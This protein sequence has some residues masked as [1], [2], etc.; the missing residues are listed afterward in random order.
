[1]IRKSLFCFILIFGFIHP[2]FSQS[3][4]ERV[5]RL[6]KQMTLEEK[7]GQLL[8]YSADFSSNITDGGAAKPME[9]YASK[10]VGCVLNAV[11]DDLVNIQKELGE[12]SRLG[13]PVLTM[14]DAINGHSFYPGTTI[15]PSQLALSQSWDKQLLYDVGAVTAKE[16]AATGIH[17]NY[18]PGLDVA[19]DLRWG[20]VGETIGEDPYLVGVLGASRIRGMQGD[21]L[22]QEDKVAACAKHLVGYGE[23][24]GGR[25]ATETLL[26]ERSLR[27]Y[28]LPPFKMAVQEADVAT[29]M[30]GYHSVLGV[31]A[32]ANPWLLN[33]LLRD[34][35]GFEGFVVSDWENYD[36]LMDTHLT[37]GDP[38]QAAI[39]IISA[40]NDVPMSAYQLPDALKT[41]VEKGELKESVIDTACARVLA[42]KFKLGL[43]DQESKLYPHPDQ[44]EILANEEHRKLALDAAYQSIVLLENKDKLLPL[45]EDVTSIAVIGPN[46]DDI[47]A[48]LGDWSLGFRGQ[49]PWQQEVEARTKGHSTILKG[50]RKRAG[51]R[52]QVNYA[53]A[54]DVLGEERSDIPTA[55]EVAKASDVIVAVVGDNRML[56]GEQQD[57]AVLE[58]TGDQSGLIEQLA[59]T[60]KPLITVILASKPLMMSK[61]ARQSDALFL[62]IN[63]GMSGGEA[64]AGLLFGDRSPSGKLTLSI[65]HHV[66][67]IPMYYNEAPG[68]HG[69]GY[70]VDLDSTT[71]TP[72]YSFGYGLSYGDFE[73][74]DLS[75]EQSVL[76]KGESL[77]GQFKV[78]NN[79][80]R[81]ATEICQLYI[82]DEV[83]SVTRPARQLKRFYKNL[84]EPGQVIQYEFEIPYEELAILN[85]QNEWV[86]E[87]GTFLIS[88]GGSAREEDLPLK[89]KVKVTD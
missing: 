3:I 27:M 20:R 4:D 79:S 35:Y 74:F 76:K 6:L 29:V 83:A 19:R 39:Q 41:A 33:D 25:D 44:E 52:I 55:L 53:K 23:T 62:A 71:K 85:A 22:A 21:D 28:H 7:I 78:V 9:W 1:M 58:L 15:F 72:L 81:T 82:K 88:I 84:M 73:Y 10:H 61:V 8:L 37:A 77:K 14:I 56:T 16:M 5:N 48:Q 46:A 11:D 75:L 17:L 86:V 26:S 63:P 54:C 67:Q 57:R 34:E 68:W 36:R 64:L 45:S 40:G 65:P 60:G 49:G 89:I 80:N 66:G 32:S 47:V 18:G 50:I 2:G 38:I 13:I 43:F 31:P 69:K 51:K 87:P 59:Q 24:V 12:N 42:L 70:Y 30:A